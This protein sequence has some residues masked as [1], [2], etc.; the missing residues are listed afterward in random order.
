[1][2]KKIQ[3][4]TCKKWISVEAETCP[5]C[6]QPITEPVRAEA[7]KKVRRGS[8]G[9]FVIILLFVGLVLW[10]GESPKKKGS[11]AMEQTKS[12]ADSLHYKFYKTTEKKGVKIVYDI[13]IDT[14]GGSLPNKEELLAVAHKVLDGEDAAGKWANFYLP[15]MDRTR[16]W[17]ASVSLKGGEEKIIFNQYNLPPQLRDIP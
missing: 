16:G 4:P 8:M 5:K 12:V 10:L 6:G 15:Q 9:C 3:C 1:M 11:T 13:V 14:V 2:A 17:F 7:L